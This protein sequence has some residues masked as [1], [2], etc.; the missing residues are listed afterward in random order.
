MTVAAVLSIAGI[1]NVT[2]LILIGFAVALF[3]QAV[4]S[5]LIL[6]AD[7]RDAATSQ[8]WLSGSTGLVRS[9]DLPRLILGGHPVP[10]VGAHWGPQLAHSFAR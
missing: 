6:T 7:T 9:P 4:V 2:R 8:V 3:T 10:S 1:K 5:H